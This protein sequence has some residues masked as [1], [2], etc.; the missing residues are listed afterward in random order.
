MLD[1][2]GGCTTCSQFVTRLGGTV[3]QEVTTVCRKMT[4]VKRKNILIIMQ[5]NE[6]SLL[7]ALFY[8]FVLA[9]SDTNT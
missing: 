3:L 5:S 2:T 1:I 8:F 6:F 4:A 7:L 9:K